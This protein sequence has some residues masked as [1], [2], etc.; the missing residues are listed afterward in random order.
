MQVKLYPK[1]KDRPSTVTAS[2]HFK[3]R[4]YFYYTRE[5][6]NP[7]YWLGSRVSSRHKDANYINSQLEKWENICK[8]ALQDLTSDLSIP[9]QA[10]FRDRVLRLTEGPPEAKNYLTDWVEGYLHRAP[11]TKGT[12]KQYKTTLN[13]LR[14]H[15]K[16]HGKLKFKDIDLEF[17]RK[18][19]IGEYSA[20]YKGNLVKNIK[21]F[22]SHSNKE[23]NHGCE[24]Y[25][26]L[27]Y[28]KEETTQVYLSLEELK[29][30]RN[31]DLSW[32]VI[33]DRYPGL[34][35]RRISQKIASLT[36]IRDRFLIGAFTGLRVS[37]FSRLSEVNID[38]NKIRIEPYKGGKNLEVII[39]IHPVV[40]DILEKGIPKRVSEQKINKHIKELCKMAG[41]TQKVETSITRGK[42]ERE[43]KEKWS[44]VT[45]HT[46][47]RS[48]A[49]N[50]FKS[51]V[52]SL[53]IMQITGHT[54][55]KSFLKYIKISREENA[56]LMASHPFF[57]TDPGNA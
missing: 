53:S 10:Q 4:R 40:R 15:E 16:R 13:H 52:S 19:Q 7:K 26:K 35:N 1:K 42:V 28:E 44:L 43:V 29:R 56:E 2:I 57:R 38:G 20:N 24:E 5:T 55:E 17:F 48:F 6:V 8:T 11:V 41:I 49:T 21:A 22:M 3:G 9:T 32:E 25:K 46:A 54:T 39:P 23:L 36:T 12:V 31:L 47:R 14:E 30:L 50:A 45:T 18:F 33:L 34:D 37:D 51:G 27:P